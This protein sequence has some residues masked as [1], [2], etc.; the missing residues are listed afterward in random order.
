[1]GVDDLGGV[2]AAER[3]RQQQSI[4]KEVLDLV[5]LVFVGRI[6]PPFDLDGH[7]QLSYGLGHRLPMGVSPQALIGGCQVCCELLRCLASAVLFLLFLPG[8]QLL[9]LVLAY[10][11]V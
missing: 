7:E 9:G 8:K 6:V 11:S 4:I 1:M 2:L 10:F 3:V 5:D